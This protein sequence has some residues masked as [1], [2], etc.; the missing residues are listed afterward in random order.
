MAGNPHP[1]TANSKI[2]CFGRTFPK[3]AIE[4]GN[5]VPSTPIFF[6]KSPSAV[7]RSGQSIVCPPDSSEVHYEAEVAVWIG[8]QLSQATIEEARAAISGWTILND[9]TARDIQRQE[10]GRFSRA[11]NF[12]TFCPLSSNTLA[13][14]PWQ[15]CRIQCLLNGELKQNGSLTDLSHEPAELVRFLSTQMTLRPGDLVSL[16]TPPGV[17]SMKSGDQVEIRLVDDEEKTLLSLANPV[18]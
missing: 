15:N 12:D 16:G 17:G 3:H 9:V 1:I 18:V 2:V 14:L 8:A 7:I 5:A 4:L 13:E 11:K 10:N 6:L